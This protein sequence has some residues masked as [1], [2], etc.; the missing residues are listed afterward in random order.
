VPD[1][2]SVD[3]TGAD[4]RLEGLA[5]ARCGAARLAFVGAER[6]KDHLEV[7]YSGTYEG[8]PSEPISVT[9]TLR[10]L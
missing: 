6:S 9:V 2:S 5:D 10:R 3:V 4:A 1:I 8:C 7:T